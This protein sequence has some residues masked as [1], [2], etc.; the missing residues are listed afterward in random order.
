MINE[1]ENLLRTLIIELLSDNISDY[2]ISEE[3]TKKWNEKKEIEI[4]KNNGLCYENRLIFYSDFYDLKTI[5]SKNWAKFLPVLQNK[6]RF[7]IFFDEIEGYRNNVMHGRNLLKS[8]EK[9]LEGVLLDLK[10]QITIFHNK[11][12]MQD[13]FFIR[14]IKVTDNLGNIWKDTLDFNK[15]VLRSG[16]QYEVL[17]EAVDPKGREIKFELYLSNSQLNLFNENGRFN[18]VIPK[19]SIGNHETV[20]IKAFTPDSDYKNCA[21]FS[22]HI[23]VMPNN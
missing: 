11:N 1:F 13:D 23:I 19:E 12:D 14:I 18:F 15:P 2:N 16:D 5:I 10:N 9:I 22:Y 20:L 7:D 3:R 17:V 6:K 4:K 21:L 8:Q